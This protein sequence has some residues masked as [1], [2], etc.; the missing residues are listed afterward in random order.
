M[1]A[2]APFEDERV[3]G[4]AGCNAY[5][6]SYTRAGDAKLTVGPIAATGRFCEGP[7]ADVESAFLASLA[8]AHSFSATAGRLVT[9]DES[10]R[11]LLEFVAAPENPL[12]GSWQVTGYN[13]GAGA[14]VSVAIGTELTANFG[15]GGILQGSGGCNDYSGSYVSSRETLSIGP[16][17]TTR[18][19]CAEPIMEQE[20]R[21]LAVL[22]AS[23]GYRLEPQIIVLV[24]PDGASGVSLAR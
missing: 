8:R 2:D 12:V 19:A 4:S 21:F 10:G 1:S 20:A 7:A 5:Q 23:T 24:L 11:V 18:K 14:V 15:A 22:Q 9:S 6:A 13:N 3:T 17:A 16:L